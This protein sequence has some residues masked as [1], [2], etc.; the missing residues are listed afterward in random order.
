MAYK[1]KSVILNREVMVAQDLD[2]PYLRVV[3]MLSLWG[4][5]NPYGAFHASDIS[6]E[7][8]ESANEETIGGWLEG[9]SERDAG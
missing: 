2:I 3:Q 6:P 8:L 9:L 7:V 1:A 4:P 5:A